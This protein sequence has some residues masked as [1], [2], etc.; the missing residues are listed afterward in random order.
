MAS[1]SQSF[2]STPTVVYVRVVVKMGYRA[3]PGTAHTQ[4]ITYVKSIFI[5]N[6]LFLFNSFFCH[7]VIFYACC[8][9]QP[10]VCRDY[11][12]FQ[13]LCIASLRLRIK[14]IQHYHYVEVARSAFYLFCVSL[15]F[16]FEFHRMQVAFHRR[17]RNASYP[18]RSIQLGLKIAHL[19]TFNIHACDIVFFDKITSSI[20]LKKKSPALE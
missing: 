12:L 3:R 10:I 17:Q 6:V 2:T 20:P 4:Q 7:I 13:F 16:A 1:N 19:A 11:Y 8:F 14:L 18:G 15:L 9:L 5:S